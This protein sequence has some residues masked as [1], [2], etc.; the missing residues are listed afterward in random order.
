MARH[1]IALCFCYTRCLQR[2]VRKRRRNVIPNCRAIRAVKRDQFVFSFKSKLPHAVDHGWPK[3]LHRYHR[4]RP[5]SRADVAVEVE[6]P[7]GRL[8]VDGRFHGQKQ[9]P[10]IA[11][12]GAR[13]RASRSRRVAQ[14]RFELRRVALILSNRRGTPI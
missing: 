6:L 4:L 3:T 1:H 11:A 9:F 7:F 2:L 13:L 10:W 5:A 14:R 12:E 8:H